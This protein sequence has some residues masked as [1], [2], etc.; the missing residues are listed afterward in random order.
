MAKINLWHD[1]TINEY[2]YIGE[3]S[4][5]QVQ[6]LLALKKVNPN[7][8]LDFLTDIVY[9]ISDEDVKRLIESGKRYSELFN[10]EPPKGKLRPYQ[11]VNV[12]YGYYAKKAL[13]G[14]S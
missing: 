7:K 14:D 5:E 2:Y 8:G 9:D 4:D 1:E 6:K 3:L 13:L 12:A 10:S 11:T